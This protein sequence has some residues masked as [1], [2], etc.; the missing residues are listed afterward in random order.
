MAGI[1]YAFTTPLD[2]IPTPF[3]T[4]ST[5]SGLLFLG[6]W[7]LSLISGH[8][9]T[10][11]AS[12]AIPAMVAI[13]L[14]YLTTLAWSWDPA[15]TRV[16]FQTFV[17]LAVS[18]IAIGGTFPDRI[19]APAWALVLGAG[20]ASVA[21]LMSGQEVVDNGGVDTQL[22][23][24]TFLGI[25]QNILAFHL[26]LGLA[27]SAYLLATKQRVAWRPAALPLLG[28]I[29]IA[30]LAVGSRTGVGSM[31]MVFA[32]MATVSAR[33]LRSVLA[34]LLALAVAIYGVVRLSQAGL[35]PTRI[36]EWVEQPTIND[37]RVDIIAQYWYARE[38][39]WFKG[40]GAGS[41]AA[42]L[43]Q[44]Q[45][46]YRN[47]HSTFWRV[48]IDTGVVGLT[49]WATMLISLTV[50]AVK[51]ANRTFFFLMAPP[52]LAFFYTLGPVNSNM[53]WVVLGLALGGAPTPSGSGSE[54]AQTAEGPPTRV[55]TT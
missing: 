22:D 41:D 24:S 8:P 49:L 10:P 30:L 36:L 14:W 13:A 9:R 17:L 45:A 20:V 52:V 38:D 2:I 35:L 54:V 12:L 28:L 6:L 40:V 31:I 19:V 55:P 1:L 44:T 15:A 34:W 25:D 47:A 16:Q 21:T 7:A 42:Y 27:A 23:Q 18:A 46:T 5:L 39:W 43:F 53:L 29:S 26:S 33:S 48:W 32:V 11:K 50:R 37:N 3:G 4:P 51:S